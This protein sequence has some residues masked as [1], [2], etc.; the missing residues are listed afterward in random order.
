MLAAMQT[1]SDRGQAPRTLSLT[2]RL[3]LSV[4][5]VL[6][7]GATAVALAALAYGRQAAEQ[8]YD[9]LLVGAANQIAG[10]IRIRDG[11]VVAD[12]P[13]SALELL[14]LAPD[15]RV[16]YAVYDP[17]GR[18]V[19]GYPAAVR[20]A[21]S[22]GF[23]DADFAGEPARLA[24]VSRRFAERDFTGAVD[25][26]VGQ[27]TRARDALAHEITR[28][29]L[30]VVGLVGLPMI[31]LVAFAIRSALAPLR[32]IEALL[33]SRDSRDL[34][35]LDLAVPREI[36][37]LVGAI[38][39]FMA[40][41]ARQ[42]TIMRNL[43]ADAS[44]QL[45][46]PVAALRA[47][48]ELAADEPDPARQR[49]IVARIHDRAAGLGRLTDQLLSHALIIHRADAAPRET[50]DLRTVAIRAVEE[51]D[52]GPDA[53]DDLRLELPEDPVPCRADAL[54]LVEACKNLVNNAN[55]YGAPPVTVEVR[56]EGRQA[57]IAVADRG[58]GLPEGLWAG[59]GERFDRTGGVTPQSAGIGLAIASAVAKAHRGALRFGRNRAGDFEAALVIH[60]GQAATPE[61][62]PRP[63]T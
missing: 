46:T 33:A 48:A 49:A 26:V 37:Q 27:T 7:L 60:A 4:A 31:G 53:P 59:A 28:S 25:V 51:S 12:I 58:P 41:Q 13:A 3:A 5:L 47:Q 14:S 20:P 6:A 1:S 40:R 19:T 18:L 54:S 24:A 61:P 44:H 62:E 50:V 52:P 2:A 39:R 30:L 32:R 34:T 15:D 23:A 56:R 63:P 11:E 8:A 43:I 10:T 21:A 45:R 38:N 57:V 42:F 17:A 29:A 9:R 22:P 35:P 16:L 55:R 36:G